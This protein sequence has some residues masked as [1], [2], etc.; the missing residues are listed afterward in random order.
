MTARSQ[1]LILL[2]LVAACCGGSQ[3]EK[4]LQATTVALKTAG[5][6]FESWDA[7]KQAELNAGAQNYVEGTAALQAYRV[8][9]APVVRAFELAYTALGIAVVM[10]SD[11]DKLTKAV[12]AATAAK[13]AFDILKGSGP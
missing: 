9:R 8:K 2:V 4:T 10:D 5:A 7:S 13:Q 12:T 11:V 6:A 3:R 1:A